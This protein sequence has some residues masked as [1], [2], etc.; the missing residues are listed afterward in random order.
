MDAKQALAEVLREYCCG[1]QLWTKFVL[2]DPEKIVDDI[3]FHFPQIESE[4]VSKEKVI[5][6]TETKLLDIIFEKYNGKEINI[7]CSEVVK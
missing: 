3:L 6:E 7:Y 5:D 4:F 2:I 1:V